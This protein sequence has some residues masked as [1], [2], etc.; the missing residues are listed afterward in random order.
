MTKDNYDYGD[1]WVLGF[2]WGYGGMNQ[3]NLCVWFMIWCMKVIPIWINMMYVSH[4]YVKTNVGSVDL[5]F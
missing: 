1:N 4:N 5:W 2:M 3:H